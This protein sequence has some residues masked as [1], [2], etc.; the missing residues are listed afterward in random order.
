MPHN[1]RKHEVA[2]LAVSAAIA[3]LTMLCLPHSA[4]AFEEWILIPAS[5][6]FI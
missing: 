6:R 2:G 4:L 3:L 5:V 1:G